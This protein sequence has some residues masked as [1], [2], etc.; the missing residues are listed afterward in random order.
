MDAMDGSMCSGLESPVRRYTAAWFVCVFSVSFAQGAPSGMGA[1]SL[2]TGEFD[3]PPNPPMP[4]IKLLN[5]FLNRTWP[6]LSLV[7][8]VMLKE[9]RRAISCS[10]RP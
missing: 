6:V 2:T 1:P 7:S 3:T 4:R 8:T 10:H 5:W 9:R